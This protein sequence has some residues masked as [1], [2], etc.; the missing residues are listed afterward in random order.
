MKT[1]DL[2][3]KKQ[4]MKMFR[5]GLRSRAVS[6]RLGLDRSVVKEWQYLYDGGDTRWVTDMP[7]SRVYNLPGRQRNRIV[8]AYLNNS[9][10]MADLCRTFLIPKT[11]LKEWVRHYRKVGPFKHD[12]R[13]EE[14]KRARRRSESIEDLLQC[15]CE[16]RKGSSKKK[17]LSTVEHGKE[18]GLDTRGICKA[19]SLPR[20]TYYYWKSHPKEDDPELVDAI[21]TL[22]ERENYNI[23]SKRMAKMLV[24]EG[25]CEKI[26]HKKVAGIMTRCSLHAKQKVRKHPKDYYRKK[27]EAASELPSNI[28]HRDFAAMEP[29]QKLVTDITYIHIK[30]GWCF[31]SAVKDLYN[32]EIVAFATSRCLN[33]NLVMKTLEV[34]RTNIGPLENV[35]LHSD[36]GWTYTNPRF[37]TF[38]KDEGS[39]QSLSA[40]GDCWDNASM[41]SFFSTLKSETI[42]HDDEHFRNYSYP[43]M[44]ALVSEYILYYNQKRI[45]KKLNWLSPV[46]YREFKKMSKI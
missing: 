33:M 37:V 21:R 17:F 6:D 28:L 18:A 36:R 9:L 23:G 16:V 44:V 20:S 7:V 38:L 13:A 42:H 4:V 40:R 3:T 46:S 31:L 45:S 12:T 10:T 29:N 15:L 25:F 8:E 2:K 35:L 27:K 43:E 5:Q 39:I 30:S 1:I 19:L 14:D 11:V 41:E 26:N 24:L 32:N 34:L 22:Q